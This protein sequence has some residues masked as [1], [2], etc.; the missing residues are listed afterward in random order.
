MITKPNKINKGD[1]TKRADSLL[2][3][4]HQVTKL[5]GHASTCKL[6]NVFGEDRVLVLCVSA[7]VKPRM[8]IYT[9]QHSMRG[10]G[11]LL[12]H[13]TSVLLHHYNVLVAEILRLVKQLKS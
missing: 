9:L 11:K 8:A 7:I 10:S 1:G 3:F 6:F 13:N 2:C 4:Q 12:T 5:R